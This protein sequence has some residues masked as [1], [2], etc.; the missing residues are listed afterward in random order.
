M[1]KEPKNN[2]PEPPKS[3]H[4]GPGEH[5]PLAP[6]E[7]P[8]HPPM[9]HDLPPHVL[10]EVMIMKDEIGKLKGKIEFIEDILLRKEGDK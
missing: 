5:R 7:H 4:L 9:P 6:H 2:P 10:H 3:H 8:I 1:K